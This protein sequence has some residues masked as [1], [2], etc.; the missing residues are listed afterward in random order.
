MWQSVGEEQWWRRSVHVSRDAGSVPSWASVAPPENV[1][2][3]PTFHFNEALGVVIVAMGGELPAVMVTDAALT[4]P[5]GSVTRSISS[6]VFQPTS[7]IQS[8]F[9]PGV[10]K[11]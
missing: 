6:H 7:P 5:C 4:A 1:M 8:S 11:R 9:V 10:V 2:V 3:S